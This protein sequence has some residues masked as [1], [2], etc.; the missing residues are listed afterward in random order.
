LPFAAAAAI[1][2]SSRSSR[3]VGGGGDS[4]GGAYTSGSEALAAIFPSFPSL[5][6]G[7]TD[8]YPNSKRP[9]SERSHLLGFA[10]FNPACFSVLSI[11]FTEAQNFFSK[12][13][14]KNVV[15]IP[16]MTLQ[17]WEMT[18]DHWPPFL[19]LAHRTSALPDDPGGIVRKRTLGVAVIQELTIDTSTRAI[20]AISGF[21]RK[22]PGETPIVVLDLIW[23]TDIA[24]VPFH[25]IPSL[26]AARF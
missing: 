20:Q 24:K 11:G 8:R 21:G 19:I 7:L 17:L 4:G 1:R 14:G 2:S 16:I 18:L 23:A 10:G 13:V 15:T 9:L 26:S 6:F 12:Y 25:R 3:A 5:P 22:P